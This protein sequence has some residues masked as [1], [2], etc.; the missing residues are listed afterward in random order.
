MAAPRLPCRCSALVALLL[1]CSLVARPVGAAAAWVRA[2]HQ[3]PPPPAPH[4][5]APVAMRRVLDDAEAGAVDDGA[6]GGQSGN[7]EAAG[8]LGSIPGGSTT[9]NT[10][11]KGECPMPLGTC[12]C[13]CGG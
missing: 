3:L 6:A 2:A 9:A 4:S 10:K 12:R 13:S 5:T 8:A 11:K 1:L 7:E